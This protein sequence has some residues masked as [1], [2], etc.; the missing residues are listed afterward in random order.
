MMD[1]LK[2]TA[3]LEIDPSITFALIDRVLGGSG[4]PQN[5][6]RE[7]S[8]IEC[9]LME[10][11]FIR[12]LG[13]LREAWTP[14]VSLRP[15]LGQIETN[16]QFAQVVPPTEMVVLIKMKAKISGIEGTIHFC[17]PYI[18]IE[19]IVQRLTAIYM[20]STVRGKRPV[21][22][23]SRK[24]ISDLETDAEICVVGEQL[25]LGRIGALKK[26]DRIHLPDWKH[27]NA[28]VRCGKTS[29]LNLK[30]RTNRTRMKWPFR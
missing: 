12:M 28:F 23:E 8:E 19:S 22:D 25:S 11:I 30:G 10:S 2:G 18:T 15:R 13:N 14:V 26:G 4:E 3:V 9:G 29:V 27:G 21:P 16:P 6:S 17:I 5:Y 20:Y 24:L 1:P 7:I